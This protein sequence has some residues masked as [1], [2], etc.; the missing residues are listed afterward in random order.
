MPRPL[1]ILALST[2]SW[3][4]GDRRIL[5]LRV[6]SQQ[7]AGLWILLHMAEEARGRCQS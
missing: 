7:V 6:S 2:I 1:H 3:S 4:F 5:P